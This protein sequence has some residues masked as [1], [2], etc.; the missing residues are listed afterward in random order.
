MN[1]LIIGST[2]LLSLLNFGCS[3]E[4]DFTGSDTI[5]TVTRELSSFTKILA[6]DDL[7][8]KVRQGTAQL[9]E[10]TV[11]DNL[12]N[13]LKTEVDNNTL[14]IALEN[15]SYS[16]A[17]FEVNILMP[18]L[19]SLQLNDNTRGDIALDL[20]ELE[21]TV[22]GSSELQL[23]GSAQTLNIN[24]NDAGEIEGFDFT[25][26]VLNINARDASELEITC[27][28][29]LN[30]T[31]NQAATVR[32]RGTPTINASTSEDGQIIDAN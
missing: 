27:S 9:V 2:L 18:D 19:E 15:G 12:Q 6:Q 30:G 29:E 10:V 26:A 16:N 1:K 7:T 3:K 28:D 22:N 13:Q 17:N 31:V 24:N 4:D 20:N 5:I 11:N 25:T 32:Y 14:N 21:L 23:A 8:V